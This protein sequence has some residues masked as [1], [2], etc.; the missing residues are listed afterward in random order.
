[1]SSILSAQTLQTLRR[2]NVGRRCP[3][4]VSA[5]LSPPR[6]RPPDRDCPKATLDLHSFVAVVVQVF[7]LRRPAFSGLALWRQTALHAPPLRSRLPPAPRAV[8]DLL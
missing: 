3:C 5:F 6:P 4:G 7:G 1:M 2:R 8:D